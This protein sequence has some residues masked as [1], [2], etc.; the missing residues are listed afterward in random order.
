MHQPPV[1][2]RAVPRNSEPILNLLANPPHTLCCLASSVPAGLKVEGALVLQP[3]AVSSDATNLLTVV[4]WWRVGQGR[5][6]GVNPMALDTVE[7]S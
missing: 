4:V 5:G 2:I 1:V 7:E 3:P 6:R